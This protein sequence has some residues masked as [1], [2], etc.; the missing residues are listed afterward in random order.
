LGNFFF[1]FLQ[2]HL[3]ELCLLNDDAPP[4]F[5]QEVRNFLACALP[6]SK[7]LQFFSLGT[8]KNLLYPDEEVGNVEELRQRIE[9]ACEVVRRQRDFIF[10][11]F[12][13]LRR[14]RLS[15]QQTNGDHF[16]QFL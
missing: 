10:A 6:G 13:L 9:N 4:H 3:F 11:A 7:F 12:L 5:R 14:S 16:E 15:A 8:P 1:H 2:N